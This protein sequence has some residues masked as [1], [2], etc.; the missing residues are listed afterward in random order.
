MNLTVKTRNGHCGIPVAS[1]F[2][3]PITANSERFTSS[4]TLFPASGLAPGSLNGLNP[5]SKFLAFAQDLI[6]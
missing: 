5:K 1:R 4:Y 3:S 2:S 6:F